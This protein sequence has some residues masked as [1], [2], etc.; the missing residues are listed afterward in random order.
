ML[1]RTLI[2]GLG[3]LVIEIQQTVESRVDGFGVA[4][5]FG[6]EQGPQFIGLIVARQGFHPLFELTVLPQQL[7]ILIVGGPFVRG[8]DEFLV[9]EL[10]SADLLVALIEQIEGFLLGVRLAIGQQAIGQHAQPQGELGELVQ[11]LDAR[12]AVLGDA[13]AG[14]ANGAHLGQGKHPEGQ[15]QG[16]DQ[17]KPQK[18]PRRDVHIT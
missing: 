16:A 4:Q 15:H 5:Q 10:G 12:H 13:F 1:C 3:L 6:V 8:A 9:R 18:R 2:E 11:C 14:C 7:H 17:G